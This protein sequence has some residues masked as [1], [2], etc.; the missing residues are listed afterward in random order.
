MTTSVLSLFDLKPQKLTRQQ[1][2]ILKLLQDCSP[3]RAPLP[4]ILALGIA[5]YNARIKELRDLGYDV[6]N[7]TEWH[8]GI[9]FSWF[10]LVP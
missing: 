6:R 4:D 5:Q 8:D 2:R 9:R 1:S 3:H 7:E 10:R